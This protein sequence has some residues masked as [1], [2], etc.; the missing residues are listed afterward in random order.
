M[1][2]GQQGHHRARGMAW[3]MVALRAAARG[4]PCTG[5]GTVAKAAVGFSPVLGCCSSS[6]GLTVNPETRSRNSQHGCAKFPLR[7]N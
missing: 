3:G 1:W 5:P 4:G 2:G 7:A 6:D